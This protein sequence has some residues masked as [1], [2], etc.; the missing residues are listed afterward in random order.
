MNLSRRKL[1]LILPY[2]VIILY[3]VYALLPFLWILSTSLK[4]YDEIWVWPPRWMPQRLLWGN[5]PEVFAA[6]PFARY[7]LNSIVISLSITTNGS[8]TELPS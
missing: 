5:Y 7:T 6:R 4:G 1:F 8:V 2:A 3:S